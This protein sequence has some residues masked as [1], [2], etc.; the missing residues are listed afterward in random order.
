MLDESQIFSFLY[1]GYLPHVPGGGTSALAGHSSCGRVEFRKAADESQMV[2][3]GV[4]A[5]GCAFENRSG[6]LH[7]V[8]LSGGLDSRT[9]L[10]AL[11]NAGLRSRIITVTFG[12][13]RTLDYEIGRRIARE[14]KV[15]H[16]EIDLTKVSLAQE[17]LLQTAKRTHGVVRVFDAYFNSLPRQ[18]LGKDAVY[19]SGVGGDALTSVHLPEMPSKTPAEAVERFLKRHRYVRSIDLVGPNI[20]QVR[21][22]LA[23]IISPLDSLSFDEQLVISCILE[24]NEL[25]I[26]VD[27][28]FDIRTPL[29]HPSWLA[30]LRRLPWE[31]RQNQYLY[32]RILTTAYP[33]LFSLPTKANLGLSL[34]APHWC[35]QLRRVSLRA[36]S[37]AKRF[38]PNGPR[39]VRRGL[40]YIDFDEALRKR[41]DLEALVY[42]NLQDLKH[43]GVVDWI[44]IDRIWDHH[45]RKLGNHAD[46]LT[47]LASLEINLKVQERS[48]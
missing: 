20:N 31:Y 2:T 34:N 18:I 3:E 12:T 25:P 29:L 9:I 24:G 42:Q 32:R 40:N 13:P 6:D 33:E 1:F 45:Q 23:R 38:L 48:A 26:L 4:R 11:L 17:S 10:G 8:P 28:N 43:R 16:E 27:D 14:M 47:L 39:R 22:Y 30:F 15:R 41:E 46:A 37:L 7:I 35:K 5:L 21:E 44:D 36:S 19:W